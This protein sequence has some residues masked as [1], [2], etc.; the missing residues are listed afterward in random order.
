VGLWASVCGPFRWIDL[1]G[2]PALYA[3]AMQ[4]VLP[5][6]SRETEVPEPL[7]RMMQEGLSGVRDGRGFYSYTAE[8]AAEWEEAYRRQVWRVRAAVDE[9]FPLRD[10][11]SRG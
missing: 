2:G 6:L 11:V 7:A 10:E 9:E 1:T 8:Q 3:R 5:T 4:G